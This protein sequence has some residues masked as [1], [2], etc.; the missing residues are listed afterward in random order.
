QVVGDAAADDAS[1]DDDDAGLCRQIHG[2]A[3]PWSA[4]DTRTDGRSNRRLLEKHACR[5]RPR[6]RN[7]QSQSVATIMSIHIQEERP[8]KLARWRL[9]RLAMIFHAADAM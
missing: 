8:M 2:R 4:D 3:I 7:S 5:I 9:V 6:Q 1:A